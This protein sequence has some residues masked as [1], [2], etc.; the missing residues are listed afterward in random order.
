MPDFP[1]QIVT[2]VIRL[3]PN[4]TIYY[5]QIFHLKNPVVQY[6]INQA[7]AWEIQSLIQK[8]TAER[9][10]S[11]VEMLGTYEIKNNQRN[12]LS[13]TL[14]NYTY[15][16]QAAHGMTY[17]SSLTF[18]LAT[19][20]KYTLNQLFKTGSHYIARL[21]TQILKQISERNIP[22][23]TDFVKIRPDQDFYIADKTLVIYF[24]LYEITP[25]VYGFPMF[26]IS[27]YELEDVINDNGP[28]AKMLAN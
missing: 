16:E 19:G 18:D 24:Q 5:P 2:Q 6:L 7:I 28:L 27:V 26:P 13:L 22:L 4:Q 17:L 1:V 21:S 10:D 20:Q 14:A 25:Y 12:I 15:H 11:V 3:G 23:I 8:Q 9:P